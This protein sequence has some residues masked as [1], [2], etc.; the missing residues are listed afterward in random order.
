MIVITA[1]L[2]HHYDCHRCLKEKHG[3]GAVVA[4]IGLSPWFQ[5]L[6]WLEKDLRLLN[7]MKT[8]IQIKTD[9]GFIFL[10]ILLIRQIGQSGQGG[11]AFPPLI[12]LATLHYRLSP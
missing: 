2:H 4:L 6:S 1:S 10:I 7:K 8:T 3:S 11:R 9:Y 5:P 12:L